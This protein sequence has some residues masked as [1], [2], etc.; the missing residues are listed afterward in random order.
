MAIDTKQKR[1]S[2]LH[3]LMPFFTP[4]VSIDGS[5]SQADRQES[6]WAYSGILAAEIV[7]LRTVTL[8]SATVTQPGI[9]PSVTQPGITISVTQPT[10]TITEKN[11]IT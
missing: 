9:T 11:D 10:I 4:S 2:S 1:R 8:L 3:S 7:G 5:M 6:A